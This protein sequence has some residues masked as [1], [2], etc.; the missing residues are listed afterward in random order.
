MMTMENLM[1]RVGTSVFEAAR[2]AILNQ[3]EVR[4]DFVLFGCEVFVRPFP[5][6]IQVP[7][8]FWLGAEGE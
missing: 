6:V 3:A 5:L 2:K 4:C 7:N 8:Y 1:Q